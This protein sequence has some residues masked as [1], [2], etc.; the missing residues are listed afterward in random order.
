M[1]TLKYTWI[2][3]LEKMS[4]PKSFYIHVVY[5]IAI[6]LSGKITLYSGYANVVL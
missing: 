3:L 5:Q 6:K 2:I 4:S 1:K